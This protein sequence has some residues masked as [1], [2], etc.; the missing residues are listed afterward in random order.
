MA[1]QIF[2]S[3]QITKLPIKIKECILDNTSK[4]IIDI[5]T[6]SKFDRMNNGIERM[7]PMDISLQENEVVD[8]KDETGGR[9]GR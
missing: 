7:K 3:N 2:F 8:S 4:R 9:E 6:I 5:E 1:V